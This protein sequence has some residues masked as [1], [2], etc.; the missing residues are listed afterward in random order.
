MR[1]AGDASTRCG[2]RRIVRRLATGLAVL[3]LGVAGWSPAGSAEP[4][5][6]AVRLRVTDESLD[7]VGDAEARLAGF[8][9]GTSRSVGVVVENRTAHPVRLT[10]RTG[11]TTEV[12]NGCTEP[13]R[14][15]DRSCGGSGELGSAL[16]ISI[17]TSSGAGT[18]TIPVAD[19]AG[20][21]L[22]LPAVA[23]GASER[24]R[25]DLALPVR[26]GNRVQSDAVRFDLLWRAEAVPGE[27]AVG[28]AVAAS[29]GDSNPFGLA[30]TG[31]AVRLLTLGGLLAAG[32]GAL[33]LWLGRNRRPGQ[34][35][36]IRS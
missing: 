14:E 1:R 11:G 13:E 18:A 8:V 26:V 17:G 5:E 9:P 20:R 22:T 27:P 29:G 16:R 15:V 3:V 33:A 4:A 32:A 31:A 23:A 6:D 7:V 30:L 21:R 35:R 28:V 19:A 25:I 12:E 34:V 36:G 2:A 10:V 24:F